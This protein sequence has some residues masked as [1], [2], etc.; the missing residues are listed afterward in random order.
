M[1]KVV[2]NN[3]SD[4]QKQREKTAQLTCTLLMTLDNICTTSIEFPLE[5]E[6]ITVT[7]VK[8]ISFDAQQP[9]NDERTAKMSLRRIT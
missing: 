3:G 9:R 2:S 6:K 5:L 7:L 4:F 1:S 8:R